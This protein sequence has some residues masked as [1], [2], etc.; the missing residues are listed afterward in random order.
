MATRTIVSFIDDL[1]G[2]EASETIHFGLD[3]TEYEIDVNEKNAK[4][5]RELLS[6]YIANAR[7]L[8]R[9]GKPYRRMNVGPDSKT[10]RAWALS[11]GLDCPE[12]GRIPAAILAKYQAAHSGS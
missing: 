11:Q 4:E 8:A 1:D 10:V 6:P 3:G 12:R 7:R 2:S 5:L 9:N